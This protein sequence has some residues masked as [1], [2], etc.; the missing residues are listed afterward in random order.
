M[1]TKL[2]GRMANSSKALWTLALLLCLVLVNFDGEII[3]SCVQAS[4]TPELID[5]VRLVNSVQVSSNTTNYIFR[6]GL[7]EYGN[8]TFAYNELVASMN[9]ALNGTES[10][11][12]EFWLVDVSLLNEIQ[13]SGQIAGERDFFDQ[14][15]DLGEL[16]FYP[17]Y[18]SLLNPQD[19]PKTIL[20]VM[21]EDTTTGLMTRWIT[22]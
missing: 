5:H 14:N 13:E 16:M 3:K 15:P 17:I 1:R 11:P 10:L 4:S 9:A 19:F 2:M 12:E 7:P 22:C 8:E 18:G 6:G 21:S 20:R